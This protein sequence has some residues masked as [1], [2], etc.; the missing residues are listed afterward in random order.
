METAS[1]SFTPQLRLT[2]RKLRSLVVSPMLGAAFVALTLGIMT[3]CQNL[4]TVED[5]RNENPNAPNSPTNSQPGSLNRKQPNSDFESGRAGGA[6]TTPPVNSGATT[7]PHTT[8]AV[9][10]EGVQGQSP[11]AP[12][13]KVPSFLNR[14]LPKI[15]LI[16]GAGGMKAFAHLGVLHELQ[17][18]RIPVHAMVGMEWGAVIGG[19]YAMQGQVNEAEWKSFKLKNEELPS[20]GFLSSRI[21]SAA[22]SSMRPFLTEVFGGANLDRSKITFAC[23]SASQKNDR[24]AWHDRGYFKDAMAQCLPYPPLFTDNNGTY[25]EPFAINEAAAWLRAKGAN[26]IVLVNVMGQ[27][28]M[29]TSSMLGEQA[30][31]NLL[32]SEVRRNMLNAKAPV[33]NWTINVNTSGHPITDS[34]GRRALMEAGTK[35]AADVVNKIAGQYGF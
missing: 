20:H 4:Q 17:R 22:V 12:Q 30:T 23:P 9:G 25:A 7:V 29:F 28:E 14:E 8:P 33:I 21:K 31:E 32:W 26:V 18:A 10:G 24:L 11:V 3:G 16:L 27:G 35:S 1:S 19:L 6:G 34:D 13:T 5:R 2:S 15:G